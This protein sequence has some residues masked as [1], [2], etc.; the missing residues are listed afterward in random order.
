MYH[1][2]CNLPFNLAVFDHVNSI[3]LKQLLTS[4]F[5]TIFSWPMQF[6]SY[7]LSIL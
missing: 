5:E 4:V 6:V 1:D 7:R 2:T 3:L